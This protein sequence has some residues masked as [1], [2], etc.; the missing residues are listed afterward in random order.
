ML[1]VVPA[2]AEIHP[3]AVTAITP[4]KFSVLISTLSS[5]QE[6]VSSQHF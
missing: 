6:S 4:C 5:G 2:A 1:Q 3:A